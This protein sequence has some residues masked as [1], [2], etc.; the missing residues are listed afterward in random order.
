M[1]VSKGVL[2]ESTMLIMPEGFVELKR[3]LKMWNML[4][5]LWLHDKSTFYLKLQNMHLDIMCHFILES[6]GKYLAFLH[7]SDIPDSVIFQLLVSEVGQ[8]VMTT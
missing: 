6:Y 4:K 5:K 2:V 7:F 8:I 3:C 1:A